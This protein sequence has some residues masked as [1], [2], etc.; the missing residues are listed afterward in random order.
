[1]ILCGEKLDV[2]GGSVVPGGGCH[3]PEGHRMAGGEGGAGQ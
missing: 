2:G 1:M 3:P